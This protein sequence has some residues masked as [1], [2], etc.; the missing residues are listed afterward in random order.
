[1]SAESA[2]GARVSDLAH[3][4]DSSSSGSSDESKSFLRLCET[5]KPVMIMQATRCLV[6][7]RSF[8]AALNAVVN[9]DNVMALFHCMVRYGSAR[10]GTAQFGSVCTSTAV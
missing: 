1:M 7:F 9:P 8:N 3:G 6:V 4:S 10:L 5:I 2:F